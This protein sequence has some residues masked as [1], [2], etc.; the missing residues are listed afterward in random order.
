METRTDPGEGGG[1][2]VSSTLFRKTHLAPAAPPALGGL[3]GFFF[4]RVS[5]SL[6]NEW[7]YTI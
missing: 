6:C 7:M 1:I 3:S 2:M 5:L 4:F